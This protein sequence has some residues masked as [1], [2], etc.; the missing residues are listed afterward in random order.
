[1]HDTEFQGLFRADIPS[2][3]DQR[4]GFFRADQARQSLSAASAGQ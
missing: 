1:M 3:Q 4:Q 2:L